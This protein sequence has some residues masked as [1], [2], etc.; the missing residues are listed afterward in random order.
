VVAVTTE[1]EETSPIDERPCACGHDVQF[2]YDVHVVDINDGDSE[3]GD[4]EEVTRW[5]SC[6][7]MGCDC[8]AFWREA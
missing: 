1:T 4:V 3:G 7:L 6:T 8:P 5:H 2:H